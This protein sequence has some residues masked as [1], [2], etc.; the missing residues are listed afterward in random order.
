VADGPSVQ[1]DL[2]MHYETTRPGQV[3]VLG[4]D[5]YNG[6][7]SQLRSFKTQTGATYPLLLLG[8]SS[9]GGNLS[10]LYGP[11]DNY[12][13]IDQDGI[14][15]YHASLIWPHGNRYHP[16]E[17][18]AVVDSILAVSDVPEDGPPL[19]PAILLEA[20]PNPFRNLTAITVTNPQDTPAFS[21]V[22]V[23]DAAGRIVAT[24]H[25]GP[26][27]PGNTVL[28]WNGRTRQRGTGAEAGSG[29]YWIRADV[30]GR[31][32]SRSILFLRS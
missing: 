15:R 18:L 20:S 32:A 22:V 21:R 26:L 14:V 7:A 12:V 11:Y 17:I 3:Q 5:L 31:T 10:T 27:A 25:E 8:S 6:T 30:G 2:W 19:P 16:N 4:A 9:I 13:V 28:R 1:N 23:V 29:R 24:L